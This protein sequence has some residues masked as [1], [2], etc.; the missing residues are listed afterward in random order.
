MYFSHP[1]IID[2]SILEPHHHHPHSFDAPAPLHYCPGEGGK[3]KEEKKK[4]TYPDKTFITPYHA[5][6]KPAK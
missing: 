4:K 2:L 3:K 1:A 5:F 6:P